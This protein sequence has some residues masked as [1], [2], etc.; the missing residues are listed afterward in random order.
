M[1]Q[2]PF[3]DWKIEVPK[4]FG[5]HKFLVKKCGKKYKILATNKWAI[6]VIYGPKQIWSKKSG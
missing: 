6:I 5:V 1:D 3:W 2:M 4:K